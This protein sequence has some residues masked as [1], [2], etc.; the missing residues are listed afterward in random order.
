MLH[1]QEIVEVCVC[2]C[3]RACW[4]GSNEE[5]AVAKS[6][7]DQGELDNGDGCHAGDWN[8]HPFCD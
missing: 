2:A 8:T 1:L 6:G 7:R 4:E 5:L 3:A